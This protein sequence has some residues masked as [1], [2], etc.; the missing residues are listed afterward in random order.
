MGISVKAFMPIE[1]PV[2]GNVLAIGDAAAFAEVENQGALMCGYNAGRA[3]FKELEGENGIN[4]Y[5]E[6]WQD[7][8]EFNKPDIHRIAQG[9]AINPYY[10][11][12][13]IDY[14]FSLAEGKAL[15]GTINQYKIPKILW[16]AIFQYKERIQKE[17]PELSQKIEGVHSM[18]T[19]EAFAVEQEK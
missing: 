16:D 19:Q 15:E 17:R 9:F 8:F 11:D 13:E 1:K 3:M 4:E 14:L 6:W 10:E 18:T 7:S 12:E 2:M 5:L